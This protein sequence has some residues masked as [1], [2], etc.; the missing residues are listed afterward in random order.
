M[1]DALLDVRA[2]AA[3][4]NQSLKEEKEL[5]ICEVELYQALQSTRL[6]NNLTKRM[7]SKVQSI[8]LDSLENT[9]H[10]LIFTIVY[11]YLS[12]SLVVFVFITFLRHTVLK[13][14]GK[15]TSAHSCK[16]DTVH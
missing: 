3:G 7:K 8:I 13:H 10:I 11:K 1:G 6:F 15:T 4:G 12:P 16:I 2:V 5:L 9:L 14:L